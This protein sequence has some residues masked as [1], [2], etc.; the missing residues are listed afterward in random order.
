MTANVQTVIPAVD[1]LPP[2]RPEAARRRA[3][4]ALAL[5]SAALGASAVWAI[6]DAMGVDFRL[7]DAQ[8]SVVIGL[9]T[10]I[11]FTLLCAGLGWAALAVLERFSRRAV[12]LWTGLAV[13]VLVLSIVPIFLEHATAGTRAG[14]VVIHLAVA[15]VVIPLLRQSASRV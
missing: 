9:P 1:Q 8:S 4:R 14:L 2:T 10:V 11:G 5:T 15:V 6:A 7:R 13:A 3:V 12:R